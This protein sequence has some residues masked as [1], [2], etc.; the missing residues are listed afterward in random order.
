MVGGDIGQWQKN[1]VG[2][3]FMNVCFDSKGSSYGK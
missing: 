3:K 2:E 1:E